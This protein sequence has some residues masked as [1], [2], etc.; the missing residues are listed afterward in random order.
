MQGLHLLIGYVFI[1][2]DKKRGTILFYS[3]LLRDINK[4]RN[5]KTTIDILTF[6]CFLT[7]SEAFLAFAPNK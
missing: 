7:I 5:F 2:D 6:E 4:E 3:H 1:K